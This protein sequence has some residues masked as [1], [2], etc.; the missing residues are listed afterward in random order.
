MVEEVVVKRD[1]K[2]EDIGFGEGE[3]DGVEERREMG[4][5]W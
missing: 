4:R 1:N 2:V 3:E 5:G